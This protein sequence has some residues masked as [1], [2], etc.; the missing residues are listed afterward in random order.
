MVITS[1]TTLLLKKGH[2]TQCNP[3]QI[4]LWLVNVV[5]QLCLAESAFLHQ[6]GNKKDAAKNIED[7]IIDSAEEE[8]STM[9]DA[10]VLNIRGKFDHLSSSL[11]SFE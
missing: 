3:F 7:Q 11:L 6:I 5:W 10:L 4:L 1:V 9:N 8:P 2:P